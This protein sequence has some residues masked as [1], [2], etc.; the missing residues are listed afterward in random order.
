MFLFRI[1]AKRDTTVQCEAFVIALQYNEN[2]TYTGDLSSAPTN[3][4]LVCKLASTWPN[5]LYR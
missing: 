1:D 3:A 4:V 5:A 2:T